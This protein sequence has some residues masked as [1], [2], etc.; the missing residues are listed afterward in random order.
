MRRVRRFFHCPNSQLLL[1]L[2]SPDHL[3][4]RCAGAAPRPTGRW[5]DEPDEGVEKG[6]EEQSAAYCTFSIC[7]ESGAAHYRR[8]LSTELTW[9]D[10]ERESVCVGVGL[11]ECTYS[12]NVSQLYLS[13]AICH[14]CTLVWLSACRFE[15]THLFLG[16]RAIMAAFSSQCI[17]ASITHNQ[18]EASKWHVFYNWSIIFLR[19][20]AVFLHLEKSSPSKV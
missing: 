5:S 11:R 10:K 8:V 3:I 19:V 12:I 15:H 16:L 1:L 4:Q 14:T 9:K 13:N 7:H 18:T 20:P 17:P 6:R 2:A